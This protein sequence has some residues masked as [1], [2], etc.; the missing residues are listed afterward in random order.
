MLICNEN[1]TLHTSIVWSNFLPIRRVCFLE[2]LLFKYCW[3]VWNLKGSLNRFLV[4][5][6]DSVVRPPRTSGAYRRTRRCLQVFSPSFLP[7]GLSPSQSRQDLLKVL[8][9]V[10]SVL[11]D[12]DRKPRAI[13]NEGRLAYGYWNINQR[14]CWISSYLQT[15]W[16]TTF[17]KH[18]H[19]SR[20]Q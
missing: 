6:G 14:G 18:T 9:S 2:Q 5:W 3:F 11:V 20:L 15:R 13:T 12:Y 16:W 19:I 1:I 17:N 4:E 7:P 8:G 10:P